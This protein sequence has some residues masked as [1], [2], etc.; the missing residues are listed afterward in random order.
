[1]PK[2]LKI[3]HKKRFVLVFI[4]IAIIGFCLSSTNFSKIVKNYFWTISKPIGW[5][6]QQSVNKI[7]PFLKDFFH[8]KKIVK[9]N[10]D[11]VAEN[12]SLQSRLAKVSEIEYENEILKKELSFAKTQNTSQT[13]AAAIIGQPSGYL[14]T[15]VIDKG[16]RDKIAVGDAVISQGFLIGVL[17]EVRPNNADVTLITDFNSLV[18]VVLQNSRGTGLLRGGL[19]GLSVEDIPLNIDIKK[20]ENVITSGLGGQIPPGILI[21]KVTEVISYQGEIFQK[22]SVSSS[23]DFSRLEVLFIIKYND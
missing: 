21:G 10:S 7:S 15:V 20:G 23:V 19:N 9:Q 14:K 5:T 17:T 4:I 16:S 1:M 22:V 11:L 18:P 3:F 6:F 12:L 13:I 2:N 8:L